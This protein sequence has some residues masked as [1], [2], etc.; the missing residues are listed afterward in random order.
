VKLV[1]AKR[2]RHVVAAK[3]RIATIRARKAVRYV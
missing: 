3:K 1:E 2:M